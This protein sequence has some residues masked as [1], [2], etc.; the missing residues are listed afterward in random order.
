MSQRPH[1]KGYRLD[2]ME[3]VLDGAAPEY[4]YIVEELAPRILARFVAKGKDYGDAYK[5]LGA[6]GQF[7]DINRKF[8]KLYNSIWCDQQLKGEGPEECA[9]DIIGHCLLL[10]MILERERT[11]DR[12]EFSSPERPVPPTLPRSEPARLPLAP[13]VVETIRKAARAESRDGSSVTR[14]IDAVL[15]LYSRKE[16]GIE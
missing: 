10:I 8:W 5:L 14:I 9:E 1:R 11:P 2:D 7:S 6:K 3:A 13:E 4:K 12:A 16:H 15:A